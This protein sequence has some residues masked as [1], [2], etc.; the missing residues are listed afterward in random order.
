MRTNDSRAERGW[1]GPRRMLV[2]ALVVLSATVVAGCTSHAVAVK[3]PC[4]DLSVRGAIALAKI[5]LTPKE[6][7]L[8]E[9]CD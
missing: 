6:L 2:S 9:K 3:H 8:Q 5:G 4:P 1:S 7:K